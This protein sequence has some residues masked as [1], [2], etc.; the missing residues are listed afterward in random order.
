MRSVTH[1]VVAA[2]QVIGTRTFQVPWPS[3]VFSRRKRSRVF[4]YNNNMDTKDIMAELS[5]HCKK[6]Y[7]ELLQMLVEDRKK[8]EVEIAEEREGCKKGNG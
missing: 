8:R 6:Y 7:K 3:R 5:M 2:V 1:L 4:Q